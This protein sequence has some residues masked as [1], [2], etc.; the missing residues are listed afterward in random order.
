[1]AMNQGLAPPL[2]FGNFEA[3][4]KTGELRKNG[5]PVKLQ[6]QPFKVLALLLERPGE[7]VT[8]EDIHQ[9]LWGDDTFVDFERGLNFAINRIREALGD[10]ADR[11]RYIETL[12]RRGYRFIATLEGD[13]IV[14]LKPSKGGSPHPAAGLR[15]VVSISEASG[16][17]L[18]P[19]PSQNV[20][21][22]ALAEAGSDNNEVPPPPGVGPAP[23]PAVAPAAR[24]KA[25]VS[26]RLVTIA[27]GLALVACAAMLWVA[28]VPHAVPKVLRSVRLTHAGH[29]QPGSRVLTDGNRLYFTERTGG[30][31]R[32][33]QVPLAGGDPAVIPTPPVNAALIDID[34]A[35]ARLLVAGPSAQAEG[36]VFLA[37][38][39]GGSAWRLGDTIATDAAWSPDGQRIAYGR[40]NGSIYIVADDGSQPRKLLQASGSPD[41]LR[42]SP[43]GRTIGFTS[44]DWA[45]GRASLWEMGADGASPHR[46][47]PEWK[48]APG[49]EAQ[50][51]QNGVWSPDGRYFVFRAVRGR[52]SSLWVACERRGWFR[53]GL[54][55]PVQL[56]ISPDQIGP[57]SFSRDGKTLYFVNFQP[58]RELVRYDGSRKQFVPYL[59]GIPARWL[60][61]SRDGQ[62]VAYRQDT[63]GT[64]WRSRIDG[65]E[66]L[67]L[68]FPPL[69]AYYPSWSPAGDR[70]AFAAAAPGNPSALYTVRVEGGP[71]TLILPED[72][73]G[74]DPSWSPDGRSL[75]FRRSTSASIERGSEGDVYV[76]DW[77]SRTVRT[78][79]GSENFP[80]GFKG[81]L[82]SPDGRYIA[83]VV[84]NAGLLLLDLATQ[85]WSQLATGADIYA[86]GVRWSTDSQYVYYQDIQQGEEQPIFRV[87]IRDRKMETIASLRQVL[88]ADVLG[89][90]MTGLAPDGSPLASLL[91]SSSDIY[92]LELGL[93]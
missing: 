28:L 43:D 29:A 64:L 73:K 77:S 51:L 68:T 61:F 44:R 47:L 31:Y 21:S 36:P 81:A 66:R 71:S 70:I 80:L 49:A 79:P 26:G 87:R 32:V 45:S 34:P 42:W 83:A 7:L 8:R 85:R 35:G 72:P 76:L 3:D 6:P 9:I 20:T 13:A 18:G 63:D 38:A 78:L 27:V 84:R 39:T 10:D 25:L 88:S 40:Q 90:S 33:A 14:Q 5:R 55:A 19:A 24:T 22:G 2:R 58:R 60:S 41:F 82:W 30:T 4:L 56:Y 12:P 62:W 91:H 52:A 37:P 48:A 16:S 1:M 74:T 15:R 89:Y 54:D 50:D 23:V 17:A 11:P 75:L 53:K 65:S 67:Q 86:V 59:G 92:A 57:P 69:D 93:P 46:M